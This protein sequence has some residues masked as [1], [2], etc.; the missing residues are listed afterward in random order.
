MG[1]HE[2]PNKRLVIADGNGC[3]GYV[4]EG[5]GERFSIRVGD[6]DTDSLG[7]MRGRIIASALKTHE[8]R[9]VLGIAAGHE[10]HR[11][12]LKTWDEEMIPGL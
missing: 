6:V 5:C 3:I 7:N 10:R 11:G 8:G 12:L 1:Y 2:C 4:C 9:V